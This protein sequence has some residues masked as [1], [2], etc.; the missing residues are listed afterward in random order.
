MDK[1]QIKKIMEKESALKVIDEIKNN[2]CE[3]DL[4]D[5]CG[6]KVE[7]TEGDSATIFKR[8]IQ[9]VMCGLVY[10]DEDK[11]C[12][13][14]ELIHPIKSGETSAESLEYRHKLTLGDAKGFKASNHSELMIES[15]STA[16]ARPTQLIEKLEGQ[17][18]NIAIGCM[19]FFDR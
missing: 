3:V 17:D 2:I 18:F 1:K 14:Q 11:K 7:V 9:A 16:C 10:W 12:M 19:S 4:D 5:L 13:V 15:I 6:E 8:V